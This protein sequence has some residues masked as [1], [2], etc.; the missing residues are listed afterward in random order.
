MHAGQ[1]PHPGELA[2]GVVAGAPLHAL[3]VAAQELLEAERG[4]RGAPTR[5][6]AS[7]RRDLLGGA[8]GDHRVHA[9]VDPLVQRLALHRE[10][11]QQRRDGAGARS[12][13]ATRRPP[14]RAP[15]PSR[16]ARARGPRACGRAGR[17]PPRPP[18]A[19]RGQLGVQR[20]GPV[21]LELARWIRAPHAGV[22]R[23]A[24]LEVRQRRLQVEAGAAH[25]DRAA[26]GRER[27]VDLAR[28]RERRT[29]RRRSVSLG[30][31]NESSRC[32]SRACSA[33]RRGAGERLEAAVHLE[34]VGGDRQRVARRA[35]AGAR[36]ARSRPRSCP[37]RWGRT[38]RS[39]ARSLVIPAVR[40]L[41]L[42]VLAA[43]AA[44]ASRLPGVGL[45]RA[46]ARPR[47]RS[48]SSTCWASRRCPARPS[49]PPTLT[50]D[51]LDDTL[52]L[53]VRPGAR[54]RARASS[55]P[56]YLRASGPR[57]RADAARSA[58]ADL[59]ALEAA[60]PDLIVGGERGQ[61]L[62]R[63]AQRDRARP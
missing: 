34:R 52:A 51:A 40:V 43:G 27:G 6:P 12:R 3:D 45:R 42:V 19:R 29:P 20:L 35:R 18:G 1:A 2:L 5:R 25:H 33:A 24:Q 39:C 14:G 13:G 15:P 41:I 49:G 37:L 46:H 47:G 31:T 62:Y 44:L 9:R 23:R 21:R 4:A 50:V 58:A 22:G 59:P 30:S 61:A 54:R 36:R 32:S 53:G 28:A 17:W 56:R 57:R 63:R 48:R 26:P 7:A 60:D 8:G 38:G 16:A 10:A 55:C 11:A